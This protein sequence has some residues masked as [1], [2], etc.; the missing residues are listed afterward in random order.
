MHEGRE[1]YIHPETKAAVQT[2]DGRA[3]PS[4]EQ[5]QYTSKRRE[6]QGRG[7]QEEM[8]TYL[9]PDLATLG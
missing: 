5:R 8:L 9:P 6:A 3:Y 7:S 4:K 2:A 1:V